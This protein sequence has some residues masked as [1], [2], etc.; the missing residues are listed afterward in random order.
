MALIARIQLGNPTGVL[1]MIE[2]ICQS[3]FSAID[4]VCSPIST[5]TVL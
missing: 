3:N 1:E 2:R 4:D 5:V